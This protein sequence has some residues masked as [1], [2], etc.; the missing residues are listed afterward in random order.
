MSPIQKNK[1][2][3]LFLKDKKT[4]LLYSLYLA[5]GS[6]SFFIAMNMLY[7]AYQGYIWSYTSKYVINSLATALVLLIA[8]GLLFM[9]CYQIVK[10]HKS[11]RI[12]GAIGYILL[13]FYPAYVLLI[14]SY[15]PYAFHYILLLWIPAFVVFI[16]AVYLWY[17]QKKF[18]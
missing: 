14:D 16:F 7:T 13:I 2:K 8:S 9:G 10:G 18:Q 3:T 17:R 5:I 1:E 6:V 12:L 15:V 11:S 4:L